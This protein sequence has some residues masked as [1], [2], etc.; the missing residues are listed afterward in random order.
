[1]TIDQTNSYTTA[2]I[3]EYVAYYTAE[4]AKEI[5]TPTESTA[6]DF[7]FMIDHRPA[8]KLARIG[9]LV[10]GLKWA[11]EQLTAKI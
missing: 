10:V 1:M 5:E 6:P 2:Q 8:A 4:I 7:V 3:A 9:E 11:S